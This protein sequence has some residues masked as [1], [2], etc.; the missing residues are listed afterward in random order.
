MPVHTNNVVALYTTLSHP[1]SAPI[2]ASNPIA[3]DI[4]PI[5]IAICLKANAPAPIRL[6]FFAAKSIAFIVKNINAVNNAAN[7]TAS[8]PYFL[9]SNAPNINTAPA[10]PIVKA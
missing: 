10:M 1:Y 6:L 4:K 8:H 2:I 5:A 3:T 9:I 7:P